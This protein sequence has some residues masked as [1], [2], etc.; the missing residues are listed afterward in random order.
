MTNI[1]QT[2]AAAGGGA[3]KKN[4]TKKPCGWSNC[5]K[6][7]EKP[8]YPEGGRVAKGGYRDAW[9][10]A[11]MQPWDI[12]SGR[13][14]L[15]SKGKPYLTKKYQTQAHHLVPTTCVKQTGTL[16]ENLVLAGYDCDGQRNGFLL[17]KHAIDMAL[18]DLQQHLGN[19][20]GDYMGPIKKELATIETEFEDACEDQEGTDAT[21]IQLMILKRMD[22]LADKARG[23]I[24]N[25]RKGSSFW[26]LRSDTA[27]A[28][29]D[30]QKDYKTRQ[31]L[32]RER[33]K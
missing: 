11:K 3:A 25:I 13:P 28:Y 22:A 5:Q 33:S 17:P 29:P 31:K 7:E 23:K 8:K 1:K 19:H 20:P 32:Y 15:S 10:G 2:T 6:H 14:R 21:H 27:T 4:V 18:H 16:K 26:P 24:E 9:I 30:A 12:S